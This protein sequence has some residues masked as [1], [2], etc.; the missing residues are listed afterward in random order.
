MTTTSSPTFRRFSA[1][2]VSIARSCLVALCLAGAAGSLCRAASPFANPIYQVGRNPISVA[3]GDFNGDGHQDLVVVNGTNQD[4]NVFGTGYVSVLLNLGDGTFG[5]EARFAAGSYPYAVAVGDFN[6]DGFQDLA[7][8]NVGAGA[9][10]DA[11]EISMRPGHGD[12]TFGAKIRLEVGTSPGYV[13]A[14]DFNGDGRPDLIVDMTGG[15]SMLLGIGDGTFAF[16]T[17][18]GAAIYAVGD[19]NADGRQDLVVSGGPSDVSV[20]LGQGDGTFAPSIHAGTMG[21]RP[22]SVA[23]GDVDGDGRQDLVAVNSGTYDV[24]VL[25]GLGD[26]TF[27]PERRFGEVDDFARSVVIGD[28]NGDGHQDLVLANYGH[29]GTGHDVSIL[30][31]RGDGTFGA[32]TRFEVGDGPAFI[33]LGDFNADGR[34]D[35]AVANQTSNTLSVLLGQEDGTLGTHAPRIPVEAAPYSVVIGDFNADGRQDLVSAN[36]GSGGVSVLAGQGDGT[37]SPQSRIA[38]GDQPST[39]AVGDFNGDGRA[40]VAVANGTYN[41][42]YGAILLGQGDGTFNQGASFGVA[43]IGSSIV[44]GD[45]DAD[46]RADLVVTN[47]VPCC[48][49]SDVSVF[50]GVGDGTFAPDVRFGAGVSPTS[51]AIGDF[52]ADGRADLAVANSG[53]PG[54][55]GDVSI[56]LGQG[57]GTFGPQTRFDAGVGPHS[58]AV[59]DFNADGRADLAVANSGQLNFTGRGV[60]ILLGQGDGTFLPQTGFAAGDEPRFIVVGDFNGDQRADLAVANALSHDVSVLLGRGDGTF[61]Q[62]TRF[63]V[64]DGPCSIA[65]GDFNADGRQDL[66]VA[67]SGSNDL[68]VLINQGS[69]SANRPPVAAASA[70]ASVECTSPAGGFLNL[71]GSASSDP[72]STPGTN[73]GITTFEWF[74]N[75]GTP[76]QTLLGSGPRIAA[77]LPLGAHLVVLR[78]TDAAGLTST[79]QLSATV[80]DTTPPALT[81]TLSPTTLWPANR[82]M[83]PVQVAWRSSDACDPSARVTLTSVTST[84]PDS[85]PGNGNATGDILDASIGTP[86]TM[87]LLRA[88]RSAAGPGR[89]YTLTYTA[90]DSSGNSTT[91]VGSVTVPHDRASSATTRPAKHHSGDKNTARPAR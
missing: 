62:Q 23:L 33:A 42:G 53:Q 2:S 9:H 79:A 76:S 32:Q 4:V 22:S 78:V 30:L 14:G 61:D 13:T 90:I 75:F 54:A 45:L 63:G 49:E 88:E 71:D 39:L 20:M 29:Y 6:G 3:L 89:V 35:L 27:G 36:F 65:V 38:A 58:I 56:L 60:S 67:N 81:L 21:S 43:G 91:S 86:D 7:V 8:T 5:P 57:D 40:D 10:G 59:G 50:L 17:R 12:G 48:S 84:A 41:L 74:E 69:L 87:V 73:D 83:V 64:G 80:V 24:S 70:E 52:N 82:R 16:K 31:G 72:D 34:P 25:L 77:A 44:V 46:G 28:F 18:I 47:L 55:V 51:V 37:F 26:G 19:V 11:G 68:S 15:T 85:T 1:A 66:V